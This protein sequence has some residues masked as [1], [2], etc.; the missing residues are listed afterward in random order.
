MVDLV[1]LCA[2]WARTPGRKF[3][4]EIQSESHTWEIGNEEAV[5]TVNQ[6]LYL[7]YQDWEFVT[8]VWK[9]VY[10][11]KPEMLTLNNTLGSSH[12]T[13]YTRTASQQRISIYAFVVLSCVES[14]VLNVVPNS[15]V[16]APALPSLALF[17]RLQNDDD[18]DFMCMT[19]GVLVKLTRAIT[20]KE[21][22]KIAPG[23][24]IFVQ[25]LRPL[26]EVMLPFQRSDMREMMATEQC[27]ERFAA[28]HAALVQKIN[29][30]FKKAG[31]AAYYT[32][33]SGTPMLKNM[34]NAAMCHLPFKFVVSIPMHD[35]CCAFLFFWRQDFASCACND[36]DSQQSADFESR[37]D[38][39][40]SRHTLP[41]APH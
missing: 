24:N 37:V 39:I 19:M 41:T 35:E 29:A 2:E 34:Y 26:G 13:I 17:Q 27:A 20:L 40:L 12:A 6:A 9:A 10:P 7:K 33:E 28:D 14:G 31:Y 25:G 36:R 3:R 15:D 22:A 11:E 16:S 8:C 1:H 30:H 21:L 4:I 5:E 38:E 23:S 32:A 18:N